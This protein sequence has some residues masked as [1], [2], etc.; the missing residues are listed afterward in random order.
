LGVEFS[1]TR[2]LC[3]AAEQLAAAGRKAV[4]ALRRRCAALNITDPILICRLF[5]TLVLPILG[6]AADVCMT[7][8]AAETAELLHR[9]FLR[10]LLGVRN[11]TNTQLVLAEFGRFPLELTWWKQKLKYYNRFANRIFRSDRILDHAF[12]LQWFRHNKFFRGWT[13]EL[14]RW[15]AQFSPEDAALISACAELPSVD[16]IIEAAQQ[17]YLSLFRASPSQRVITYCS[18]QQDYKAAAYL[19]TIRNQQLLRNLARFRCSNHKL[20]IET[21]RY[22]NNHKPRYERFCRTCSLAAVETEDHFLLVCPTY[23]HL[24]RKFARTLEFSAVTQLDTFMHSPNQAA[25]AKF[26]CECFALRAT[27]LRIP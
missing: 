1:A 17:Q 22:G 27:L 24:R 16:S 13:D 20:E 21:G 11:A 25:L 14:V 2:A 5:D 4:F 10:S 7:P 9:S 15:V 8:K 19:S 26:I 3:M 12:R 6:Y 18:F 23:S